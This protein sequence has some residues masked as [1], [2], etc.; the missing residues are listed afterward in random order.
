MQVP[1]VQRFCPITTARSTAAFGSDGLTWP[2]CSRPSACNHERSPRG[3]VFPAEDLVDVGR[4]TPGPR[5]Q[6]RVDHD[7]SAGVSPYRCESLAHRSLH[8]D[9][10]HVGRAFPLPVEDDERV[11][12]LGASGSQ[13][14]MGIVK[15]AGVVL[16]DHHLDD[17]ADR[18]NADGFGGRART[19]SMQAWIFLP[20]HRTMRSV[21]PAPRSRSRCRDRPLLS[22]PASGDARCRVRS[23][24]RS[25]GHG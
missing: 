5:F 10:G 1:A 7:H 6:L 25:L 18:S 2:S 13:V 12:E 22:T 3:P 20:A 11:V 24:C 17:G 4:I 15:A 16:A 8:L 14:A 23:W 9:C 19:A 21:I